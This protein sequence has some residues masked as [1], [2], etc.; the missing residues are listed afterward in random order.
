MG[1]SPAT[2]VLG[3]VEAQ[4]VYTNL[5]IGIGITTPAVALQIQKTDAIKIPKGNTSERPTSNASEHR[6]YIRY[7]SELDIF[8]GFGAGNAWNT[9]G[10]VTDIDQ[11]TYVSAENSAGADNDEI[12]MITAGSERVRVT[13]TGLV[14]INTPSPTEYLDVNGNVRCTSF[15]TTSDRR[16]KTDITEMKPY[17]CLFNISNIPI[18]RYKFNEMYKN[19]CGLKDKVYI[20][21][22]AQEVE[23]IIPEAVSTS[24]KSIPDKITGLINY[25]PDFKSID[26]N[27][28]IAQL[29][30]SVKALTGAYVQLDTKY[31]KKI[32]ELKERINI[33][34][35]R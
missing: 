27:I 19:S 6:G 30:G 23:K 1:F 34:E 18:Y 5:K 21:P 25:I 22:I 33:L 17:K 2:L 3:D 4:N 7:N 26:N 32:N 15:I 10:G 35:Q 16:V 29:I 11:D 31:Q 9:L 24:P 20:G 14:G 13:S 12:K 28:L 8:E